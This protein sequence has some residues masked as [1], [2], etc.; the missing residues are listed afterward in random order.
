[1][2]ERSR[3][4]MLQEALTRMTE[5]KMLPQ[6]INEFREGILYRTETQAGILYWLSNEEKA[7][8]QDF[9]KETGNL[10]YHLIKTSTTYGTI[11]NFLY[12]DSDDGEWCIDKE[13]I[14]DGYQLAYAKN[15]DADDCSE[16]G[17]IGIR[18]RNGG[19]VRVA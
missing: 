4:E 5:F 14:R 19:L 15:I 3:A 9:E 13:N 16:Y 6:V 7:M 8:V 18:M 2:A 11:Y 1:M 10:V 17:S 12:V